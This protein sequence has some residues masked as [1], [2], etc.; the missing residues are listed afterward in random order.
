[1][2]CLCVCI[3]IC[4][5]TMCMPGTHRDQKRVLGPLKL[6]WHA[7]KPPCVENQT[8]SS[9]RAVSALNHRAMSPVPHKAFCVLCV[10]RSGAYGGQKRSWSHFF[11]TIFIL[12]LDPRVLD[13]DHQTGQQA[14][15]ML[16]SLASQS[17]TFYIYY[18]FLFKTEDWI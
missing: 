7:Y 17:H 2:F 15:Y 3:C 5:C 4:V 12:G 18:L 10:A 1:M 14:P 13:L 6:G 16:R 11:S 8:I 9:T